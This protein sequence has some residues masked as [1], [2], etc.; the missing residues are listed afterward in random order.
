MW[1]D[2]PHNRRKSM[3]LRLLWLLLLSVAPVSALAGPLG[4][5]WRVT[6][7]VVAEPGVEAA[8]MRV[9]S[10]GAEPYSADLVADADGRWTGTLDVAPTRLLPLEIWVGGKDGV[11]AYAGVEVLALGDQR[12]DFVLDGPIPRARRVSD[13]ADSATIARSEAWRVGLGLAWVL[14]VGA[15]IIWSTRRR[16]GPDAVAW[17]PGWLASLSIWLGLAIA[18]TWP[19]LLAGNG[20]MLGRFFD[21]P[22]TVWGIHAAPRLLDGLHDLWTGWPLGGDYHRLDSF[23]LVP[24][25]WLFSGIDPVQVHGLLMVIGVA[26]SAWAA[27][28]FAGAVGAR[29]PWTLLAGLGFGFSGLAANALI[30]GHVYH[31]L[32]PWLP[33]FG[34]T[35]WRALGPDG[36]ARD[37]L[38][39]G[40]FFC[41]CLATTGYLGVVAALVGAGMVIGAGKPVLSRLGPLAAAAAV[42]LIGGGVYVWAYAAGAP[43]ADLAMGEL[44][45]ISAHLSGLAAATPELDRTEHALAPVVS[46]WMLALVLL[47]PRVL[48]DQP[49]LRGL[50]WTAVAALVLSMAP[51]FSASAGQVLLPVSFEKLGEMGLGALVRFPVRLGW[52]WV[53][54]GGVVAARVATQ[55]APRWGR[56]GWVVLLIAV[57]ETMGVVG[58][59]TR[60][61]ERF[62]GPDPAAYRSGSGPVLD[63]FPESLV[64]S[65][66]MDLWLGALTCLDQTRHGRPLAHDCVS[67][68][69]SAAA[70]RIGAWVTARLF[71]GRVSEVAQAL[72]DLGFESLALHEGVFAPGDRARLV[73]ALREMDPDPATSGLSGDAIRVY[74]VPA[75]PNL[76]SPAQ[77]LAGLV[78]PPAERIVGSG[79][80]LLVRVHSVRFGVDMTHAPHGYGSRM[81]AR[82]T[83]S[84]GREVLVPITDDGATP[85]DHPGD[86]IAWG[87][88]D[89]P[90]PGPLAVRIERPAPLRPDVFWI[91]EVLPTVADDS[92]VW[93]YD[94]RGTHPIAAM[95]GAPSPGIQPWNGMVALIG[96]I[97]VLL[98]LFGVRQMAGRTA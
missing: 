56:M 3:P 41:L 48:R 96:W 34:W 51:T 72:R 54:L 52:G 39:A 5:T 67:T 97:V 40:L 86:R 16:P 22:G 74:R 42:A 87:R 43:P 28:G 8:A 13:A 80:S 37:G 35:L 59:P 24:I 65:D 18:W 12:V 45:P 50:M 85:G 14:L 88:L 32:D 46:A 76:A 66:R 62:A 30:E 47:A 4:D 27:Q 90:H 10:P 92:F 53:L 84:E 91:G 11:R 19:A 68:A 57:V 78:G 26:L 61:V 60:Q 93:R 31:V 71:E 89:Q 82:V 20:R 29:A 6:V 1:E 33:L 25:G 64:E 81:W 17:S 7:N 75:G 36:R 44:S 98:G 70:D 15:A 9:R 55:L 69:G 2:G 21:A 38:L 77:R 94:A 79:Q 58:L 73:W 83:P 63:L 23:T 95:P 49:R